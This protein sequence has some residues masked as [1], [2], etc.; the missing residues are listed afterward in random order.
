MR[1][2]WRPEDGADALLERE[3]LVA[4][5]LGGYATGTV[6]GVCTRRYHGL[7]VASL[8]GLGRTVMLSHLSDRVRLPSRRAVRLGAEES[9]VGLALHG[10]EHLQEFRLE[11][12][13]PVWIFDVDGAV[14]EKRLVLTHGQNTVHLAY[15]LLDGEG[16]VR[17]NLRPGVHFRPH[18]APVSGPLQK[19]RVLA[20]EGRYEITSDDPRFPPLRL[21]LRGR[22][23]AFTFEEDRL[24]EVVYRVEASRGYDQQGDLHSPGFFR[25]DLD[26][27]APVTLVASTEPWETAL[28]MPSDDALRAERARREG[29]LLRAPDVAR[30]GPAAELVLAADAFVIEPAGRV[31]EATHARAEGD[32]PRTIIAGY[33]WFTDWGRDT[34]ISLEGLTLATGQA[35]EAGAILRAFARHVRDG[36]I[37]N[38]FP[39]GDAEGLYHTADA[40]LWMFHAVD[41]YVATTGDR[42]TLRRLLPVMEDVVRHHLRGTRFG[43]GVDPKDGLLRQGEQGY[44]LTWMDAKVDGW[45]V[46]PRRGKAVEIN[47]LWYHA[48]RILEAWLEEE[49]GR[50]AARPI[51]EAAERAR[52]SFNRRFWYADGGYLYD[53]VDGEDGK[54]D[55]AC[56]PNQIFAISLGHPVLDRSRWEPVVE[57]VRARLLTP[58]GLRSLS[59]DH[60]DYKASYHGDLRTR[61][62]AYHQG[63]VWSWLIGPYVD[64]WRKLHPDDGKTARALLDGLVAELG[65]ACIGQISEVFDAEP[66][67]TPRGCVAQAWGVAE[68]LRVLLETA[69]P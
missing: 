2:G 11:L 67:F 26:R 40:T 63:T 8:P 57:T 38:L 23:A 48:L 51:S 65:H 16:P 45:V 34:M 1:I 53:V 21:L 29:L 30:K 41:R 54:D 6:A 18:D 69:E 56:R 7:L 33:H 49:R 52:T 14:I 62:A 64:A 17:L 20:A 28:A 37:P 35:R 13:L 10:A 50:D 32:Q 66:P 42:D 61:D 55:A 9:A 43:I 31:Q 3:W 59:R 68:V 39:E 15:R 24:A 60:P 5:G 19:F 25:V 58:V 4:N 47:A 46:T 27:G 22:R 36:L 44:Q 12:G